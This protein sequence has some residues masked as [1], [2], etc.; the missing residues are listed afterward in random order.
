[1]VDY[2]MELYSIIASIIKDQSD[3]SDEKK[4]MEMEWSV[5]AVTAFTNLIMSQLS[6]I[7][8][9]TVR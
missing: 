6:K 8:T 1:M 4:E 5:E 2:K 3:Q 9:D 7:N